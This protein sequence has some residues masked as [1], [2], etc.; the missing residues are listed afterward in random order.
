MVRSG[1]TFGGYFS[2]W[3]QNQRRSYPR[4]RGEHGRMHA[5]LIAS[6]KPATC[7]KGKTKPAT[8]REKSRS[9]ANEFLLP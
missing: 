1:A 3:N 6:T 9:G 5:E 2:P 4:H 7:A 8:Y